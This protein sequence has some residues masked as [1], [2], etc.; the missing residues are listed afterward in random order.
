[1]YRPSNLEKWI[2]DRYIKMDI[3]YPSDLKPKLIAKAFDIDYETHFAPAYSSIEYGEAFIVTDKRVSHEKQN[4]QFFHELCHVLLHE[5]NQNIM[6]EMFRHKQEWDAHA[7]TMYAAIPYYMIDFSVE[8]TIKSL[9][10][11]FNVP[12]T[13]A[14]KRFNNIQQKLYVASKQIQIPKKSYEVSPYNL[15]GRSAETKRLIMQLNRQVGYRT[16]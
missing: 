14:K 12:Y 2:S 7:F 6:V 4:E 11:R 15:E 3:L 10:E 13:I 1:M 5:G 8:N 16:I 9:Q